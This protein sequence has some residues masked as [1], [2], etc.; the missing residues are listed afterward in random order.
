M[1]DA[2]QDT[3]DAAPAEAAALPRDLSGLP[4]YS[5]SLLRVSVPVSVQLASKRESVGEIVEMACGSILT[6][7]KGCDEPL[8]LTVG[9][10]VLAEGEAVKIGDKF[11]FRVHEMVLPEEHFQSVRQAAAEAAGA[12]PAESDEA[13]SDDAPAD[14]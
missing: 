11:G 1:S 9:D 6:F 2:P 3:A 7:E 10:L 4:P 13:A 8:Q 12:E 14:S 5:R